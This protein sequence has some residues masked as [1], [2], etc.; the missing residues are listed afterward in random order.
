MQKT[1]RDLKWPNLH[2]VLV[3][4]LALHPGSQPALGTHGEDR[5]CYGVS[6]LSVYRITLLAFNDKAQLFVC[7]LQCILNYK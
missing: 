7:H 6:V 4:E 3:K 1:L 5:V 2:H